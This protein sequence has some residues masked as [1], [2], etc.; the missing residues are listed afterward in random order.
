MYGLNNQINE[1]TLQFYFILYHLYL[2]NYK[3]IRK[4]SKKKPI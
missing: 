1:L 4:T 3:R 2:K